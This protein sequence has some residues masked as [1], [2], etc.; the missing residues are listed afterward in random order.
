[1]KRFSSQAL[2]TPQYTKIFR[3][4]PLWL[5]QSGIHVNSLLWTHISQLVTRPH[6]DSSSNKDHLEK[7]LPGTYK[8]QLGPSLELKTNHKGQTKNFFIQGL[9]LYP[10]TAQ[11]TPTGAI[12][13]TTEGEGQF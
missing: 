4:G 7:K 2:A 11:S 1:M 9:Y 3:P 13:H 8:L 6:S 5:W 12:S 10:K